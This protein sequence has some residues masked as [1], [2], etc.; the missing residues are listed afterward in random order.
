MKSRIL[1]V[2]DDRTLA[3]VL[4]DNLAFV[5]FDVAWAKD[6]RAALTQARDFSPDLIVLDL[7]LPDRN[8]F[9]LLGQLRPVSR[10]PI[11]VL[12][13]RS[14]KADKIRGLNL[15]ADDYITKPFDLDELLA[16][17]NAVL[18][19]LR[20]AVERL[21][22]GAVVV[23]VRARTATRDNRDLRLTDQEIEVLK[24]LAERPDQIV[25]RNELLLRVW[26]YLE[27][28]HTRSVDQAI[29]RL[30]KKIEPDPHRPTFILTVHGNG[31]RLS[32]D[33]VIVSETAARALSGQPRVPPGCP[34]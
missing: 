3:T 9:D 33:A 7:M 26:R 28:P 2:E 27:S 5:G 13:A 18:R 34:L 19:R 17:V 4:S 25:A 32:A 30:R 31:Y 8:G 11:V 23:D 1:L 21:V 14:Q 10:T 15:G 6:G 12:T 16:R 24:Y 22:L 20:P 29:V